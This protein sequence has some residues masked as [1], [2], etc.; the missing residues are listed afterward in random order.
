MDEA[1]IQRR[2][3]KVKMGLIALLYCQQKSNWRV[4]FNVKINAGEHALH[5]KGRE[6]EQGEVKNAQVAKIFHSMQCSFLDNIPSDAFWFAGSSEG[7][8]GS[9]L[10]YVSA[11]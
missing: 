8:I 1:E 9:L 4:V 11:W 3:G 10:P 6:E 7:R 2:L 5:Q